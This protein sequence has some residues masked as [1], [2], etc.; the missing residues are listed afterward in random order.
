MAK[1]ITKSDCMIIRIITEQ[2]SL[3]GRF[4]NFASSFF[5][6]FS[7]PSLGAAWVI[8]MLALVELIGP[9]SEIGEDP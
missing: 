7:P 5:L 9:V 1:N 4:P 6:L 8:F 2:A 3:T